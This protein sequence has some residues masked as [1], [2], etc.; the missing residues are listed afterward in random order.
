MKKRKE[1]YPGALFG[2]WT[3]I[4]PGAVSE[5]GEERWLCRCACGAQRE[6]LW[7][8]LAYG[9]SLSCGC[10]ARERSGEATALDLS[11]QTF[12]EL[13][14]IGRAEKKAANGVWWTC[15][16]ACGK[17]VH[18]P[19]T[20][21]KT[22]KRTHCGCR[23]VKKY[24]YAD[25]AGQRFGRLTAVCRLDQADAYGSVIWR[26]RCDCGEETAFSYNNLVYGN[27]RSCGCRKRE[28]D[29][30]LSTFLAHVD[31]TCVDM[32]RSKKVPKN[33]TTGVK[34]VYL[35]RGKYVA[36]IVFKKKQY[37][38]GTFGDLESA[39]QA[40]KSAEEAISDRV[41][42]HYERWKARAAGDDAWA[43]ENPIRIFA[44]KSPAGEMQISLLP[45]LGVMGPAQG[46]RMVV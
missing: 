32:L 1:I 29:Q 20:L 46:A 34:G 25:I 28:H 33:N 7:R 6:V 35:I 8:S 2:R 36:K 24:A 14:V 37:I 9:G 23:T 13:T 31:G 41:V 19:A 30:A 27:V 18:Y 4:G 15:R 3:V 11:G 43:K 10:L 21:L 38:L 26:C 44:E 16:C 39:R 42:A 40:R 5:K 12:G 45:D 17:T 22:G